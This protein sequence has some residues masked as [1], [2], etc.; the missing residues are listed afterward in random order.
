[1]RPT[2][3]RAARRSFAAACSC[4]NR[5]GRSGR[6]TRPRHA[7]RHVVDGGH[8]PVR[9]RAE[10][11]ADVERARSSGDWV[12]HG[13]CS[14]PQASA[15]AP[16]RRGARSAAPR[17]RRR[18]S[19]RSRAGAASAKMPCRSV[20]PASTSITLPIAGL[21]AEQF[22]NGLQA[23]GSPPARCGSRRG[24]PGTVP[25]IRI[26]AQHPA[27]GGAESA[28]VILVDRIEVERRA[29]GGDVE[30]DDDI[31]RDQADR[32]GARRRRTR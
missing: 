20:A 2:T 6:R 27:R 29:L 5:T 11:A 1:M 4:R 17:E 14:A 19:R 32:A 26:V 21:G 15:I 12:G 8:A 7:E 30:N 23:P 31:E 22:G 28:R 9:R 25:G 24:S 10:G 18:R 3:V 16:V 13:H